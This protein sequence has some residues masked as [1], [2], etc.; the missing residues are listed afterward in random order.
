[1]RLLLLAIAACMLF[2]GCRASGTADGGVSFRTIA[3]GTES[4]LTGDDLEVVR[5]EDEWR[6]LWKR[7]T[8]KLESRPDLPPIDFADEMVICVLMGPQPT[9]GYEIEIARIEPKDDGF[10]L[11]AFGTTPEFGAVIPRVVTHPYHMVAVPRREG[12]V[13]VRT[14]THG[15]D[16][17]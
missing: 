10:F 6:A 1:M 4:G 14:E 3:R 8:S 15:P 13:T 2:T 17:P 7:H 16:T 9:T 5:S 12:T 11:R